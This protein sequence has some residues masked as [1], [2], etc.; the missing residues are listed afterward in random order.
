[1]SKELSFLSL[2]FIF[3]AFLLFIIRH[4]IKAKKPLNLPP[5]SYG[6]PFLG[7]TMEYF[8]TAMEGRPQK[9]VKHRIE[10]YHSNV[11]KTSIV[12]EPM[13]MLCGT[14]GNKFLFTNSNKLVTTWWPSSV[15]KL[16]G[17]C[18]STIGGD[19]AMQMRK[20]I[21]YFFSPDAFVKLYVKTMDMATQKHIKTHWQGKEE[22]KVHPNVRL[23]TFELACRL[24]MS[25]ED[26]NEIEKLATLFD[27]FVRGVISM[28][29]NFPGTNFYRAKKATIAI[30]KE[31]QML[32]RQRRFA[33]EQK[34]AAPS[35]DLLSH[36]LSSPDEN[37]KFMSESV[38]VNNIVLLLFAG[39]DTSSAALTILMKYLAELP[40]I[41]E[42]VLK[43]QPIICFNLSIYHTNLLHCRN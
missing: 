39:Y 42:K 8:R 34:T 12:G 10:K 6:W 25:I 15:S 13:A 1:M 20:M 3:T 31:L 29:I 19:E 2:L 21:S 35:Q 27:I 30:K 5:G 41:Y 22:V 7:E 26:Q 17:P 16:L 32:V 18:I 11:F 28:P 4:K 40:E 43:G 9:F 33:L 36:L 24:F 23:Y 37:G 38:I 14:A